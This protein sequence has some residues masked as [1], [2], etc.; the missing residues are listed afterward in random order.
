MP[1]C[2]IQIALRTLVPCDILASIGLFILQK[3]KATTS[4]APPS[5]RHENAEGGHS[6]VH[7][8]QQVRKDPKCL[9]THVHIIYEILPASFTHL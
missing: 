4:V 3:R 1:E 9:H 6:D 5:K 7:F 8:E 2:S